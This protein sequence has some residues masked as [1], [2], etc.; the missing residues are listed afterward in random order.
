MKIQLEGQELLDGL[1]EVKDLLTAMENVN[2]EEM[3]LNH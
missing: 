3:Q 2:E 1:Y